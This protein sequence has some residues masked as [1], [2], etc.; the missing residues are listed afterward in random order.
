MAKTRKKGPLELG[1]KIQQLRKKEGLGIDDLARQTGLNEAYIRR[2]ENGEETPPVG[3]ILQISRALHL[4]AGTFLSQAEAEEKKQKRKT[5]YD[6]RKRAYGYKVLAPGG[7]NMHLKA[8]RITIDPQQDHKMVAYQHEGE[9]FIYVLEGKLAVTV[10]ENEYRLSEGK[11][12]HFN[13]AVSH[14]LR[15]PGSAKTELL[16]VLYTP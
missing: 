13:A 4:D 8:F 5:S 12:L 11:S 3:V 15:N 14:L 16:V 6:K 9:E 7:T 10:G 2:L 1:A